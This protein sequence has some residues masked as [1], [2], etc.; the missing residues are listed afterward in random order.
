MASSARIDELLKKFDE[1]PRRYFAPLANEYRKSGDVDRA[2]QLCREHLPQQ[3]GHMSG[4]IVFG[5]AL[6]EARRFDESRQVFEAALALDPENLIA[7]RHLGDIARD[8]GDVAGARDWYQR[9]LDADPR[10]EEIA[11][12]LA[13][14][15]QAAAEPAATI[16]PDLGA[17]GNSGHTDTLSGVGD[18]SLLEPLEPLA[19]EPTTFDAVAPLDASAARGAA[20]AARAADQLATTDFTTSDFVMPATEPASASADTPPHGMRALRPEP[21]REPEPIDAPLDLDLSGLDSGPAT[22][23]PAPASREGAADGIDFFAQLETEGAFTLD[24]P[25]DIAAIAPASEGGSSDTPAEVP[26]ASLGEAFYMPPEGVDAAGA[27]DA[28]A[29]AASGIEDAAPEAIATDSRSA[30]AASPAPEPPSSVLGLET[31]EF[32]PPSRGGA[33]QSADPLVGHTVRDGEPAAA[34]PTTFVTETMAELY[35]Q[36]GFRDEALSVYRQLLVQHPEDESLRDRVAQLE[37]GSRSSVGVAAL[38]DEVIEAARQR[39]ETRGR[40]ASPNVRAFFGALAARRPTRGWSPAPDVPTDHQAYGATDAVPGLAVGDA[41]PTT[42][43]AGAAPVD[44]DEF[45]FPAHSASS[46]RRAPSVE[47]A[48]GEGGALEPATLDYLANEVGAPAELPMHESP[49]SPTDGLVLLDDGGASGGYSERGTPP[50]GTVDTLFQGAPVQTHDDAAAAALA[51]A[52]GDAA[53]DEEQGPAAR[54]ARDARDGAATPARASGARAAVGARAA[55]VARGE[56]SLDH[57]FRDTPRRSAGQRRSTPGFSFDQFFNDTSSAQASARGE[58]A[59][60]PSANAT[61]GAGGAGA[62]E[63]P[64]DIEQF[65]AWLEGLK[66]K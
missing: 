17:A 25:S 3:P 56:L 16:A 22:P 63:S 61:P 23:P 50:A 19:I 55:Q 26:G 44:Y 30:A 1:N 48:A 54:D 43:H 31:M 35:L 8:N 32:V 12:H 64:A 52:F 7:L 47:D 38:S 11:A 2:I 39:Q 21:G 14:L 65:N 66:K 28:P 33:A 58:G 29:P 40:T 45:G 20:E 10:N 27:H 36:Q 57:V 13:A 46:E 60:D 9:V 18:I 42:G 62:D 15:E 59:G 6:F 53:P 51:G 34:T 5:Q 24:V 49:S 41:T 4:H 37:S